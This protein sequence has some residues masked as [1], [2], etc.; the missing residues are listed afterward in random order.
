MI[1][2]VLDVFRRDENLRYTFAEKYQYIM[3]DEYQDTNNAQNEIL[4]LIVN[5]NDSQN[6]LVVGDDDQS[7]YRFQGA[8]LENMLH[9]SKKYKETQVLV[10]TE[11]Y[12][13]VQSI[14]NCSQKIIVNNTTRIVRYIPNISKSL[15]AA[16]T[17]EGKI[18]F[19]A[20]QNEFTEKIS[21][22]ECIKNHIETQGRPENEF[23]VI[24][25]TNKEVEEWT[26]FLQNNKIPV[27]SKLRTNIFRSR[28]VRLFLDLIIIIADP[29]SNEAALIHIL[30]S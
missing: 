13:S 27:E 21:I 28:F 19:F 22:L 2:F 10:L 7:I 17:D 9:F 5:A 24:V 25:R 11:N 26:E 23:A 6:I 1:C 15:H 3:I 12:R 29:Y 14:I 18:Q 16:R 30:R 4:E 8:N 20:Y